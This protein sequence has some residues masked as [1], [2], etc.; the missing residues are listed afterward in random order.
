M[1]EK[2]MLLTNCP[3]W[4]CLT[5]IQKNMLINNSE[6]EVYPRNAI[7]ESKGSIIL[8][9]GAIRVHVKPEGGNDITV[10][11]LIP[12]EVCPLAEP[13]IASEINI[14]MYFEAVQKTEVLRIS[15]KVFNKILKRN[16]KLQVM[17]Y[18]M[19]AQRVVNV[20]N[21]LQRIDSKSLESRIAA[22]LNFELETRKKTV[23]LITHEE[24]AKCI[25]SSREVV[26]KALKR[27][28]AEGVIELAR[29][30]I[31]IKDLERIQK[32]KSDDTCCCAKYV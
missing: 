18:K 11:H 13:N 31:I 4:T 26:T 7:I 1:I 21:V 10:W 8:K 6:I 15:S 30:K 3:F 2:V 25:N 12:G 17:V 5:D 23:I 19:A 29:G 24:I 16:T 32:I 22:C 9:S 27:M 14:E 20:I 28:T